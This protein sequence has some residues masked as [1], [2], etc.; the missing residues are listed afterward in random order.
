MPSDGAPPRALT[1]PLPKVALVTGGSGFIGSHVVRE[2][3]ARGVEVR[4]LLLPRDAA[5]T[6]D[7]LD[8]ARVAGDITDRR[9]V[10]NA[11]RG[12]DAIFNLAAIYA[13][14]LPRPARM[15][16]VNVG[17]TIA[18]M[19]AARDAGVPL[20]VH[21]SSI[22]AVGYLPGKEISDESVAFNDWDIGDGYVLS[23]YVSELEAMRFDGPDLQVVCVNPAFPFGADDTA[24]T[25]TGKTVLD[26]LRGRQ[27]AVVEGGFNAVDVRDVAVGH[28]LGALHGRSGQR[29]I[30]GGENVT[31]A[32]FGHRVAERAGVRGPRFTVPAEVMLAAGRVAEAVADHVT[33]K[34]PMFT[35]RGAAY[36]AGRYVWFSTAKAERE[37]GYAP[38]PIDDAIAA[39]VDFMRRHHGL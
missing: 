13:L 33:R 8:V 36:L 14:W 10:A 3:L 11:A 18:V 5:P 17:G 35:Y 23:K 12:A 38:R 20:V 32:D 30:L 37:L 7:G 28:V 4:C 27:P 15:Y 2:L 31:F 16:E 39:S 19:S 29:Y 9:A 22:A 25:P 26:I 24:P 34:P 6:L 1:R 21:T